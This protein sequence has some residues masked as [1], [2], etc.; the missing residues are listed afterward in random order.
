MVWNEF[1]VMYSA[2]PLLTESE[3]EPEEEIIEE[4]I[5]TEIQ[6]AAG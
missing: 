3:T 4:A 6:E 1:A 5:E 2:L